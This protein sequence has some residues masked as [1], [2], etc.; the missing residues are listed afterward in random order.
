M[1]DSCAVVLLP[2][3]K[4]FELLAVSLVLWA[5]SRFDNV[6]VVEDNNAEYHIKDNVQVE[7]LPSVRIANDK[8]TTKEGLLEVY[9]T[10]QRALLDI[11]A[12]DIV[13]PF[14]ADTIPVAAD[15]YKF[16]DAVRN[17][18]GCVNSVVPERFHAPFL[19]LH[20]T[21]EF[22][23]TVGMPIAKMPA[24]IRAIYKLPDP[25]SEVVDGPVA[26]T[27]SASSEVSE[28]VATE[29]VKGSKKKKA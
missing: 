5:S 27:E 17:V 4:K 24:H 13:V 1:S 26:V 21:D 15:G 8:V 20:L 25:P 16:L 22:H 9:P 10:I 2:S 12:T 7:T 14:C 18:L 28:V 6:L 11:G 3:T 19:E 23:P 29:E